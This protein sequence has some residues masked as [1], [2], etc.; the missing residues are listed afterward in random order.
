MV[1]GAPGDPRCSQQKAAAASGSLTSTAWRTAPHSAL[2]GGGPTTARSTTFACEPLRFGGRGTG[3]SRASQSKSL[4]PPLSWCISAPFLRSSQGC[5]G[6]VVWGDLWY[7][8]EGQGTIWLELSQSGAAPNGATPH[9][10][11]WSYATR[12]SVLHQDLGICLS[13]PTGPM[14]RPTFTFPPP[15][16]AQGSGCQAVVSTHGSQWGCYSSSG[17]CLCGP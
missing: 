7:G 9:V 12:Q 15:H 11:A 2:Q 4:G 13:G 17:V 8:A 10:E 6:L 1:P 16:W 3:H 14:H 5:T